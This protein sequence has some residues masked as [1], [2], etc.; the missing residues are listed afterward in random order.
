V[1]IGVFQADQRGIGVADGDYLVT[2]VAEDALTHALGVRAVVHQQNAAHFFAGAVA[3]ALRLLMV[4]CGRPVRI[5]SWMDKKG[6]MATILC[7]WSLLTPGNFCISATG[8]L[9]ISTPVRVTVDCWT[10]GGGAGAGCVAVTAVAVTVVAA[11]PAAPPVAGGVAR[12]SG[13]RSMAEL[14]ATVETET[15]E[16]TPWVPAATGGTLAGMVGRRPVICGL[17]DLAAMFIVGLVRK[18]PK[19]W[20]IR[21][22]L[23]WVSSSYF[24]R[25]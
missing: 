22:V 10:G 23:V 6:R 14:S 17:P 12:A 2:L 9:L 25:A 11:S 15:S 4:F 3:A 1:G 24:M 18:V 21:L 16:L 19:K 7:A 8:A 5:R 20:F 13:F